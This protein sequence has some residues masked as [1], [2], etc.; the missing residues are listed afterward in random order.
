[1]I[2][3]VQFFTLFGGGFG[4]PPDEVF[5][6]MITAVGSTCLGVLAWAALSMLFFK[7]NDARWQRICWAFCAVFGLVAAPCLVGWI[8]WMADEGLPS[9]AA[10][11]YLIFLAMLGVAITC[12]IFG[13]RFSRAAGAA[14]KHP[15][16]QLDRV[17]LG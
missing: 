17:F 6:P 11:V 12:L 4:G 16:T 9:E 15:P 2:M 13:I 10:W 5:L 8:V 1:M 14:L 7:R 3:L